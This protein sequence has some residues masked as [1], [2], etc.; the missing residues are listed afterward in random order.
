MNI[1]ELHDEE[2]EEQADEQPHKKHQS[3]AAPGGGKEIAAE[4]AEERT[5]EDH[6]V[7]ADVHDAGVLGERAADGGERHGRGAAE[8]LVKGTGGEN[9]GEDRGKVIH[10]SVP[11]LSVLRRRAWLC[12]ARAPR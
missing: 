5:H 7:H 2:R 11:P 8:H 12:G 4:H 10:V 9:A 6:A 1:T 3:H